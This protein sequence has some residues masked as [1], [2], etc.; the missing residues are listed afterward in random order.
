MAQHLEERTLTYE[1]PAAQFATRRQFR[2][3]LLLLLLNLGITIQNAHWPGGRFS[4]FPEVYPKTA[5]V[6]CGAPFRTWPSLY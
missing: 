6:G 3:V 4:P 1:R 2:L 5:R